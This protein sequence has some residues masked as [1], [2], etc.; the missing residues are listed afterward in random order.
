MKRIKEWSIITL[1]WRLELRK[2]YGVFR[3]I[4]CFDQKISKRKSKK[5]IKIIHKEDNFIKGIK[6]IHRISKIRVQEINQ[7]VRSLKEKKCYTSSQIIKLKK[8]SFIYQMALNPKISESIAEKIWDLAFEVCK[9]YPFK[10]PKQAMANIQVHCTNCGEKGNMVRLGSWIPFFN[11]LSSYYAC[12]HCGSKIIRYISPAIES[13]PKKIENLTE[14]L[15]F[16][17]AEITRYRDYEWK[18]VSLSIAL[19]WGIFIFVFEKSNDST[20][21]FLVVV[22]SVLIILGCVLLS[23]HILFVHGE[24]TTNRCWRK[25][26]ESMLGF[27]EAP[28]PLPQAFKKSIPSFKIGRDTFIIPFILFM[29]ITAFGLSYVLLKECKMPL[30]ISES[31]YIIKAFWQYSIPCFICLLVAFEIY[32]I[33]K[34]IIVQGLTK[35][36]SY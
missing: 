24:L 29:N 16:C 27:Y 5:L 4:K 20:N 17:N 32:Y 23:A 13:D 34:A 30:F 9:K 19:S 33:T 3:N 11:W 26:I 7:L 31:Y 6:K 21:V 35:R 2:R 12:P 15:K 36:G 28:S 18:L 10:A 1:E 25:N 8:Y 22:A 14:L